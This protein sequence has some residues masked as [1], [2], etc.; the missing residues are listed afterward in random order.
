MDFTYP[1][2]LRFECNKC[3]LCC[4]DTGQKTRRILLLRSEAQQIATETSRS[5]SNFCTEIFDKS[6]YCYEMKKSED[7]KCFFLK[8]NQCTIYPMRPLICMFYPFQLTFDKDKNV[9]VFDFTFEC[10]AINHG[11]ILCEKDFERLFE[12]ARQ[13]LP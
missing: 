13:R 4:G 9:H 3:S 1:S 7:C 8:E 2:N 6:P 11:R 5:I 10:P 12:L